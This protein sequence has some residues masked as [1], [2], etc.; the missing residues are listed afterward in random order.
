LRAAIRASL[1][2][3]DLGPDR[4]T[5]PLLAAVYRAVLGETDFGIHLAGPTGNYKS[6]A[7]ALAQQ[8]FGPGL[9]ARHLP[10]SWSSTGNALE[11]LAFVTKDCLVVADDFCPT[12]SA[13][14]VQRAHKDADRL[15]RGQG[16][17]SGRQRMRADGSLR[18]H[19]PPRGLI[20]S[21]GED[22]PR[23]QSLR[24]RLLVVEISPGDLGPQPPDPNPTLTACQKDAAEGKYA[25][26]LAGF[27]RWL[28]PRYEAVRGRLRAEMAELRD[29]ARGDGQH[30]RTPG[31]V[32][33]LALGLHY[34]LDYAEAAGA[35]TGAE[36]AALWRRG[37]AALAEAG[38]AQ[39][40]HLDAAE[41]AGLFLRLLS[42]ALAGGYAH[43]AAE[44]GG[45]PRDPQR[46]GWKSEEYNAGDGAGTRHKP[47]GVCVG[48]LADDELY[49]EPDASYAAVQR[50]ARDQNESFALA[51][52]TLRR[53]LKE[54]RLLASTDVARGKLTVRKTLQGER[55][56]VLHVVWPSV[57][58]APKSDAAD[59]GPETWA[60]SWAGNGHAN[61]EAAHAAGAA[62]TAGQPPAS[63][64]PELGRMGRSD[65]GE[66][67][68]AAGDNSKQQAGGWGDWQ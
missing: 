58:S 24:A 10:M 67:A 20:L 50:I 43:V 25:R 19:K 3:L 9:D 57:S 22:T 33:D 64:G 56:E 55:R 27:A 28:A 68:T 15:F 35:I 1:G 16:N 54:R 36:R 37:W 12:G 39:A 63:A 13:A 21:T 18:P 60:G 47:Q 52:H 5:F 38:G 59:D 32:A 30:A 31:I 49:L 46:W 62:G 42:A 34:F 26:A 40:T 29:Q 61:G 51:A 17:R 8:H 53:R 4:V 48:W 41:P 45:A 65:T 11:G 14:D 23:G 66:E 2:L 6:E 7:A 44:D